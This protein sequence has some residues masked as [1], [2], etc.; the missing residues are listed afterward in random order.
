MNVVKSTDS[1]FNIKN[2]VVV[3]TGATG[4]LGTRFAHILSKNGSN[5]ILVDIDEKK[6]HLL[7]KTLRKKIKI[8]KYIFILFTIG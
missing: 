6:C 4:Y 1:L 2:N 3:L 5:V 8:G 7:E